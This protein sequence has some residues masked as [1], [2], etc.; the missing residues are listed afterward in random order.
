MPGHS[1]VPGLRVDYRLTVLTAMACHRAVNGV[2]DGMPAA[3]LDMARGRRPVRRTM[4]TSS[5]QRP[6][7]HVSGRTPT[8][9]GTHSPPTST[10]TVV[11]HGHR[12]MPDVMMNRRLLRA[13][14]HIHRVMDRALVSLDRTA[15]DPVM[16]RLA[17]RDRTVVMRVMTAMTR[18]SNR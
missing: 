17:V 5:H 6:D 8:P 2:F 15:L 7:L 18:T 16:H 13:P 14:M 1:P 4:P 11:M 12:V 9:W 3:A 10:V